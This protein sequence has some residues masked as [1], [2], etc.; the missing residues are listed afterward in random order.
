MAHKTF[1][2]EKK[3]RM[4]HCDPGGVVF[5]PQYF[6]LFVEVLEDWFADA[7][8]HP[9]S[10]LISQDSSGTPAMH[11]EARF[12]APSK[13]GDTL[14]FRL[15]LERLR[16]STA[17]IHISARCASERRCSMKFL[18]GFSRLGSFGLTPWPDELRERMAE[19]LKE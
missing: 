16:S 7:L 6:N 3:V 15:H 5:T 4:Q 10:Q 19:F 18:Y 1:E 14:A 17:L 8:R 12:H 13:L 9:F 2:I 11:I